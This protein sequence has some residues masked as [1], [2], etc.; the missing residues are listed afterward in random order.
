MTVPIDVGGPHLLEIFVVSL[1]PRGIELSGPCGPAPWVVETL[2]EQHP[3]TVAGTTVQRVLG[4]PLLV[5]STSWRW[6]GDSVVLSFLAVVEPNIVDGYEGR[7]FTAGGLARGSARDAPEAIESRQVLEH[8]L[9][10]L[11]WLAQ[12]DPAVGAALS[13]PWHERLSSFVPAPFQHLD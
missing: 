7:V 8:A 4:E 5:H 9:R 3:M 11:A 12:D 6:Q 13:D 10:H 2:P 1:T